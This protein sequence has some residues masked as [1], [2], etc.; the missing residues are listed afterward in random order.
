MHRRRLLHLPVV[1]HFILVFAFEKIVIVVSY[2]PQS[3][4]CEHVIH[5]FGFFFLLWLLLSYVSLIAINI[6]VLFPFL[7]GI[8]FYN[9]KVSPDILILLYFFFQIEEGI[10]LGLEVFFFLYN[11]H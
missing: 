7:F 5:D 3:R 8:V 2:E 11:L 9:R 6:L 4:L 10:D 1:T